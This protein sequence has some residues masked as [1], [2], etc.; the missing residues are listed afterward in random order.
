M[1]DGG[2]DNNHYYAD[3]YV[4]TEDPND[5]KRGGLHPVALGERFGPSGR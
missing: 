4:L 1:D 2:P 3:E 5:Y